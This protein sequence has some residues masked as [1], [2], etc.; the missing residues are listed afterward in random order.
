AQTPGISLPRV[1]VGGNTAGT[2]SPF[3]AYGLSGQT[4]AT[5]D[6]VNITDLASG[7][8]GYIDYGAL[9]EAKIAAAGNSADVPVAG[10]AVTTVI[11]S[12]SNTHHGEAF[13]EGKI[14]EERVA[15]GVEDYPES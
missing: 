12:G 15:I 6:G 2:Q 5:V 10:A 13:A 11:K 14:G 4:I 1:D 8:G 7:I 3:R 9:A